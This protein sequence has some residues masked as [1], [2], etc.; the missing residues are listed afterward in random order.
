MKEILNVD[1]LTPELFAE[2]TFGFRTI[3]VS[4]E[5]VVRSAIKEENGAVPF[6]AEIPMGVHFSVM[7]TNREYAIKKFEETL[8]KAIADAGHPKKIGAVIIFNCILRR[9]AKERLGFS[10]LDIIKE[11]L[12]D[13]PVNW[14]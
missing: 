12:G 1:E 5:Y 11:K 3:D 8:D 6:Y 9:L 10:D 13:V 7:D 2:K 14:I 4:G